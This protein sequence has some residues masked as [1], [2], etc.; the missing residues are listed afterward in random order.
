MNKDI[1]EA[2]FVL[3]WLSVNEKVHIRQF[4]QRENVNFRNI[5]ILVSKAK[6]HGILAIIHTI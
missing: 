3:I 2:Y 1:F 6:F 4:S 5:V